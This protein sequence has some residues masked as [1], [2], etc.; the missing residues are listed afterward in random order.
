MTS[1]SSRWAKRNIGPVLVPAYTSIPPLIP[2]ELPEQDN[3]DGEADDNAHAHKN[4][5][6]NYNNEPD[7]DGYDEQLDGSGESESHRQVRVW[8][9][10][11]A[12]DE[13]LQG[14]Y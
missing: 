13:L 1:R 6:N 5:N 11:Y 3:V 14:K 8:A 10:G 12:H 2:R 9:R 4:K 7:E